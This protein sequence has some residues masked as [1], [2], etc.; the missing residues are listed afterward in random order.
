MLIKLANTEHLLGIS[1]RR[2][3]S[4]KSTWHEC[5]NKTGNNSWMG[6]E[7]VYWVKGLTLLGY[8]WHLRMW[9]GSDKSLPSKRRLRKE[10][11]IF[12][13]GFWW[14]NLKPL[15]SILAALC[16]TQINFEFD[17]NFAR[18]GLRG[19]H[20][21]SWRKL[22]FKLINISCERRQKCFYEPQWLG[23][24]REGSLAGIVGSYVSKN[25][26]QDSV[27]LQLFSRNQKL[28]N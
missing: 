2:W 10:D 6:T 22:L 4:N 7:A 14:K 8:E 25:F 13:E 16:R 28:L 19:K 1:R 17:S 21:K 11:K 27:F 3:M 15:K 18:L 26:I 20:R 5:L 23:E 9:R 24:T 12:S